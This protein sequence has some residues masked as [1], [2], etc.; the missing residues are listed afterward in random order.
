MVRPGAIGYLRR[1]VSGE[2][3][4]WDEAQIRSLA[5]RLGYELRKTIVFGPHTDEPVLRLAM[6]VERLGVEAVIVP[7]PG[8][9]EGDLVPGE[10][11]ARTDVITV[12]PEHTYARYATG[13]LPDL[14]DGRRVS[15]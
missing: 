1:D 12:E 5:A 2:R 10:L 6:V 4:Q 8:H 13:D 3:Q 14:R 7:G 11:V 9:F 15:S